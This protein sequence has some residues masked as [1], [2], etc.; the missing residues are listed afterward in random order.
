MPDCLFFYLMGIY[1]ISH[2]V[3]L[4]GTVIHCMT[5]MVDPVG[6]PRLTPGYSFI[7][8]PHFINE[9]GARDSRGTP[10]SNLPLGLKSCLPSF[11]CLLGDPRAKL[12][13]TLPLTLLL[14]YCL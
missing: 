5:G 8:S 11:Y 4:F 12:K 14:L 7:T 1:S 2:A 9:T 10:A 6:T 13:A 3:P